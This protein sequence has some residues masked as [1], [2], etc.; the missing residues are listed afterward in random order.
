MPSNRPPRGTR[1]EVSLDH[2]VDTLVRLLGWTE[3]VLSYTGF[4]S[5]G[6]VLGRLVLAPSGS[7]RLRRMLPALVGISLG[8]AVLC[9]VA[10]LAA[11]VA[12]AL[13]VLSVAPLG[14]TFTGRVA[15]LLLIWMA[16]SQ[17]AYVVA[18]PL[19]FPPRQAV[20]WTVAAIA[21]VGWRG[22]S[23]P[24]PGPRHVLRRLGPSTVALLAFVAVVTWWFWPWRGDATHVLDRMLLGWDHSG[25]F[26]MVERLRAPQAWPSSFT[27]Y[28]RGYHSL[29]ASLMELGVGRP[30]GLDSELVAYG[31]AM[32][33]VIAASVVLLTASVLDAPVFWR[34]P[35]LLAPATAAM[36]TVYLQ[37]QDA[38]QAPYLGFGNFIEAAG[39]AG[40]GVLLAVRWVRREDT[41]RWFLLG[42]AAAGIV[43]TWT[44]LL[45]FLAPVPVAVWLARRPFEPAAL[46]RLI[47]RAGGAVV[48]V[49][50]A[51]WAQ[52]PVTQAI[53]PAA[54]P[55]AG[56]LAALDRFLL[57]DGAI[58]TSAQGWPMVFPLAGVAVPLGLALYGRRSAAGLRV[59]WLWLP[60]AV[61]VASAF[62]IMG[63]EVARVGSMRYYGVKVLCAAMLVAGSVA[64][65]ASAYVLE[66]VLSRPRRPIVV[67]VVVVF[68]T[69]ALLF[70]DGG[71]VR[72]G[73]LPAS[74]GGFARAYIASDRPEE[75][76]PL[77]DAI[78]A[79]CIEVA[80]RP[81]EYYLLVPGASHDD[82]VRAN[83]WLITCGLD[84]DS[85][86]HAPV[87]RELLPDQS[88]GGRT[89]VDLPVDTR[90]ILQA[91]PRAMVIVSSTLL[92]EASRE[93]TP[94]EKG[95]LIG[96]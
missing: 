78:R 95:R 63:Y 19:S 59:A 80:G 28:P 41:W 18:W 29:V 65:L 48:M 92:S 70:C 91:R 47:S 79:S 22:L 76:Q 77:S 90:R 35:V 25:H 89:T 86:D 17:F 20:A 23:G 60:A 58:S 16:A 68:L 38:S 34:H 4:G 46:P 56:P 13:V 36:V 40:A 88:Q 66:D 51:A 31:Y 55:A 62:A 73:P 6:K 67:R 8:L 12:S 87:L 44:L 24:A 85:P 93:L 96:Y 1:L 37:F 82:L 50:L 81:G 71:P 14:R 5:P 9:L 21:A 52:P 32:L 15:A 43:G 27:G 3:P 72:L 61:A 84:W 26:G 64:V 42:C 57:A 7:S 11:A 2:S 49:V 33:L 54:Q 53:A 39:F 74:P 94:V 45:A 83:V 75:R 69:A 30:A 10:P